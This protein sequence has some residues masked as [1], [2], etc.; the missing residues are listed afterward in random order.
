MK[1]TKYFESMR[2]RNDRK[3]IEMD[4]ILHVVENAEATVV[5]ADGRIRKWAKIDQA[6][7]K[8]LRVVVLEDGKTL[9]NAF[10]DRGYKR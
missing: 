2:S 3:D 1:T 6:Q 4:W 10:F 5:Q 8:Y 7:G 9:H